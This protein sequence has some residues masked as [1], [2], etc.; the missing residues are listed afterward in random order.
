MRVPITPRRRRREGGDT[1]D[2]DEEARRAPDSELRVS[3]SF[4]LSPQTA[5]SRGP[6]R[7]APHTTIQLAYF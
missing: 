4:V 3:P 5:L 7:R 1:R 6:G 2:G